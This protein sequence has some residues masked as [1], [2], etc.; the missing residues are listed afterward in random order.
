MPPL[1]L[2]K[3]AHDPFRG[4]RKSVRKRLMTCSKVVCI[5]IP[6]S[7][8]AKQFNYFIFCYGNNIHIRVSLSCLFKQTLYVYIELVSSPNAQ[9]E[10]PITDFV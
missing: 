2:G 4:L 6:K 8:I 5:L 10:L 7:K 3:K 9:S 1:E